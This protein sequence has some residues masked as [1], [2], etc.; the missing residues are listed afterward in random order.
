MS[1]RKLA[2][3]R[4]QARAMGLARV[5]LEEGRVPADRV[6]EVQA[7]LEKVRAVAREMAKGQY[8]LGRLLLEAGVVVLPPP[9]ARS[10]AVALSTPGSKRDEVERVAVEVAQKP[11]TPEQQEVMDR[12]RARLS[13]A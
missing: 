4:V 10:R 11:M 5:A 12:V 6:E 9:A 3:V 1:E 8:R 2:R 13:A 7:E